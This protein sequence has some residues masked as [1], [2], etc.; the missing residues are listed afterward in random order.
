MTDEELATDM[1]VAKSSL[2]NQL[3]RGTPMMP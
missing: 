3:K 2:G 1:S